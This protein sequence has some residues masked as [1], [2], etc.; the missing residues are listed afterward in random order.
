M[1]PT[2]IRQGTNLHISL[3]LNVELF[4]LHCFPE[5]AA[6]CVDGTCK[7]AGY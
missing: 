3:S 5:Y 2:E 4:D 1:E 7:Q 6:G